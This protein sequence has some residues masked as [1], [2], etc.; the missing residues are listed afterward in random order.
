MV[1]AISRGE[2]TVV[3]FTRIHARRHKYE[4]PAWV[5]YT[6]EEAS[7]RTGYSVQ[8]IR[9][10]V[11]D[12]KVE[13]IK[14]GPYWLIKAEDIENYKKEMQSADDGRFGPRMGPKQEE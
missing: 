7:E 13:A 14:I 10:L 8:Y 3:E 1:T 11:R 5:V 12:K 4:M 6:V 9:R 2:S